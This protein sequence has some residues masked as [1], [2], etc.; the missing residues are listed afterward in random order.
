M[1]EWPYLT[2]KRSQL[3][4][5]LN[6]AGV[7]GGWHDIARLFGARVLTPD[8]PT[9]RTW[10]RARSDEW[11]W[12]WPTARSALKRMARDVAGRLG[13]AVSDHEAEAL[14]MAFWGEEHMRGHGEADAA[15]KRIACTAPESPSEAGGPPKPAPELPRPRTAQ[16]RR[17]EGQDW[18]EA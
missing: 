11:G 15:L 12:R 9:W 14:C 4:E 6:L 1:V 17:S 18:P 7:A 16:M 8:A 2:R 3:V 10:L 13:F 5:A